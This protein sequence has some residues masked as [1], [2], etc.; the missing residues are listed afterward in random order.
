VYHGISVAFAD[1][2]D[3]CKSEHGGDETKQRNPPTDRTIA[4]LAKFWLAGR[5]SGIAERST[6]RRRDTRREAFS[7]R[8][9]RGSTV[10]QQFTTSSTRSSARVP[11]QTPWRR[12]S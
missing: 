8:S 5:R 1:Q 10:E 2:T 9:V 11:S 4:S 6:P 12:R 7:G 3:S